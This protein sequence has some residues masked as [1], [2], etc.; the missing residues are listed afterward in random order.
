MALEVWEELQRTE[1]EA[2]QIVEKAKEDAAN[3]IKSKREEANQLI[4]SSEEDVI[5]AGEA[6]L[7]QTRRQLEVWQAEQ[8]TG[9][10]AELKELVVRTEAKIAKA[11]SI[12]I[13]KV[14]S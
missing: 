7:E 6:L 1:A 11:V 9:I 14:V 5:N 13:E 12:L 3:L 4:K 2:A 10:E 8:R